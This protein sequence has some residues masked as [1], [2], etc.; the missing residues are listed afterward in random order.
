MPFE[1]ESA[2][3]SLEEQYPPP[4]RLRG[5]GE[6]SARRGREAFV[7]LWLT[8][9]IPF[10]FQDCPGVYEEIRGWLAAGLAVHAKDVTL[11]GSARLGYSLAGPAKLGQPFGP[12]SDL[13]FCIVSRD[14][15]QRVRDLFEVW[16]EDY[17]KG[18]V[19]PRHEHERL[20]WDENLAFGSRNIPKGFID[21]NK[22]PTFDRYP[23]SQH[24]E[25]AM[26]ILIGRMKVT[27]RAP[28]ARRASIRVYGAWPSLVDRVSFNLYSA[29]AR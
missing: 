21:A 10:A 26:W 28:A 22:I 16:A 5:L 18:T 9:G 24:V 29:L 7:R 17:R 11:V 4:E 20:L 3:L 1:M 25:Q 13:D 19:K 2:L 15:F 23:L 12:T 14:L 8:K 6:R 27:A